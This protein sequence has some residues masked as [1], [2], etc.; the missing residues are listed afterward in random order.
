MCTNNKLTSHTCTLGALYSDRKS[1]K[2][3]D[4]PVCGRRR[5]ERSRRGGGERK[6][7]SR[8]GGGERKER[9]RGGGE[10]K[11]RSRRVGGERKERRRERRR[12]RE[13][14]GR[15]RERIEKIDKTHC[16]QKNHYQLQL[17]AHVHVDGRS[18]WTRAPENY[19]IH[20]Q[21]FTVAFLPTPSPHAPQFQLP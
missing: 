10:R 21:P 5:R 15:G 11:E 6:E 2:K 8:R 17:H 9:R 19:V 7:R 18:K 14:K 12:D 4:R 16:N 3:L 1:P 13:R 20:R